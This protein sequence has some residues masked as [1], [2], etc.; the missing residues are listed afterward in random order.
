[1]LGKS[2]SGA[3]VVAVLVVGCGAVSGSDPSLWDPAP[4]IAGQQVQFL[5]GITGSGAAG[6][7]PAPPPTATDTNGNPI[8][9]PPGQGGTPN[10]GGAPSYGGTP[11]FSGAP[12]YGGTPM[13]G[14]PQNTGGDQNV[15]GFGGFPQNTGGDQNVGGSAGS[16]PP[17][18][19]PPPPG[20]KCDFTFTVT[21]TSYGGRFRPQNVGAI[22]IETS[23]GGYVKSLNVWGALRLGNL[24]DWS[25]LSGGDKTDAVTSATRPNA[26]TISG[27]WDCTDHTHA[28]APSGSY[29]ACCSFTEDD[30]LPFFGPAPKQACVPFDLPAAPGTTNPPNQG[31]FTNMSLTFN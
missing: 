8:P 1:M 23:S 7:M 22:Y 27:H 11:N 25:A 4:G 28:I 20:N 13:G 2:A 6:G 5:P 16:P 30:A 10:F 9:P 21:T 12:S 19:P 15:G 29:K 14:Y 18:P 3:L 26:G 17:P 24:T 31:N